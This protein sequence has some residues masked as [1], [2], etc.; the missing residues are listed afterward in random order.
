MFTSTAKKF[1]R[2]AAL[3]SLFSCRFPMFSNS[4]KRFP[5]LHYHFHLKVTEHS[6]FHM[7][8]FSALYAQSEWYKIAARKKGFI[9]EKHPTPS[10]IIQ[11]CW[12]RMG[13]GWV[14][15]SRVYEPMRALCWSFIFTR[16]SLSPISNKHGCRRLCFACPAEDSDF[17]LKSRPSTGKSVQN[18][19][20]NF[21]ASFWAWLVGTR[22][23]R[24]KTWHIRTTHRHCW[25]Q[26][27][28]STRRAI[29]EEYVL[30][31]CF[32][33]SCGSRRRSVRYFFC[34]FSLLKD[35]GK[36]RMSIQLPVGMVPNY[37]L[38]YVVRDASAAVLK[39]R[40]L[41]LRS[42]TQA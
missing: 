15:F 24:R 5:V 39:G 18:R 13:E 41:L 32:Q 28:L 30:P 37:K 40:T 1:G 7:P 17:Q 4:L 20:F 42:L 36:A 11:V 8:L 2:V 10:S 16:P 12:G 21:N 34:P 23:C 26:R 19:F 38:L 3:G 33:R 22:A 35:K 9:P 6:S 27:K 31:I 29:R 25:F 14:N